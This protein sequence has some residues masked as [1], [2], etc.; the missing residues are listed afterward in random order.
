[1]TNIDPHHWFLPASVMDPFRQPAFTQGNRVTAL[2]DGEEY[3]DH[4]AARLAAT[5]AAGDYYHFTGW[6]FTPAARLKPD[7][8]VEETFLKVLTDMDSRGVTLRCLAWIQTTLFNRDENVAFVT[9]LDALQPGNAILDNR[10]PARGSHHQKTSIVRSGGQ[11]WAYVGGIDIAL[12]RW[13]RHSHD[14]PKVTCPPAAERPAR[15]KEL[16][17]GWHDV[18]CVIE[19]P[20]VAHVWENFTDRWNDTRSPHTESGLPGG[21]VPAPITGPAPTPSVAG[22]GDNVQVLRTLPCHDT[23]SFLPDGEQTVRLAYEQA[24]DKAEHYIYIEDQYAWPCSL[25]KKLNDAAR[26]GVKVIFCLA[27]EYDDPNLSDFHNDMRHDEFLDT[28]R[29]S[30]AANVFVFHLQQTGAGADIY[31]HAKMMIVDDCY[32]AIGSANINR[33]SHTTDSEL[34]VAVVGGTPVSATIDGAAQMVRPFARDLRL[35][36]WKEHLGLAATNTAVD[37]PIAGLSAWPTAANTQVHQAVLHET[38]PFSLRSPL[39]RAT[40]AGATVGLLIGGLYSAGSGSSPSTSLPVGAA[41]GGL[42]AAFLAQ[43]ITHS[44]MNLETKCEP[45]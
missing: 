38:P 27:H 14:S 23:H 30:A 1:M 2:I 45:A 15:Q 5:G 22:G 31:I 43:W 13:D 36:I 11:E 9:A 29:D 34:Q 3:M 18:H 40:A 6:R 28:V 41:L 4:L 25:A 32:A 35:R 8:C 10:T 39:L 7:D 44:A 16:F 26:R 33:R 17:E 20:A 12:D 24:I 21:A 42:A 37:D 19:G